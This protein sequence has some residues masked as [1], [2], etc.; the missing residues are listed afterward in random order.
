MIH[1]GVLQTYMVK[2]GI[3]QSEMYLTWGQELCITMCFILQWKNENEKVG[4]LL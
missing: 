1:K 2:K 3:D 4:H